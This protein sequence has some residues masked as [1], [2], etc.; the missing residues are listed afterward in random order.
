MRAAAL[1]LGPDELRTSTLP[2]LRL[3]WLGTAGFE[4]TCEGRTLLVDPYVSRPS[5]TRCLLGP[6][7]PDLDAI[8]RYVDAAD[9]IVVGHSH[10][11]HALD[12]PAIAHRTGATVI[13]ARSTMRLCRSAGIVAPRL[14]EAE[15]TA[16]SPSHARV[17]PFE[18]ECASS[19]HSPIAAGRIPFP[20]DIQDRLGPPLWAHQY[21]C[22]TVLQTTIRVAGRVV[23]HLGSAALPERPAAREP[24][25]VALACV[26][27]WH[28]S[29]DFPERAVRQVAP[30]RV[31][32]S[33]W[34]NFFRPLDRPLQQL[35]GVHLGQL[36]ERLRQAAP[37]L[38]VGTMPPCRP[39]SL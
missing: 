14:V 26:S 9:A 11:D 3:R 20:G 8:R 34:D 24:A 5:I 23:V 36:V 33:H 4:L 27:G 1:T 12:V 16:A 37:G 29:T 7:L 31:V 13:G 38:T 25:D 17:G 2:E 19:E 39:M 35:P 18:L 15:P 22:G 10:F 32:L 30:R 6:L 21:S 28:A